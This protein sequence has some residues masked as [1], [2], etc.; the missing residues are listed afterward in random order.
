MSAGSSDKLQWAEVTEPSE[1]HTDH[2][3]ASPKVH[4]VKSQKKNKF[5]VECKQCD[6]S[7][8]HITMENNGL[9]QTSKMG[10]R[11]MEEVSRKEN[12]FS[13]CL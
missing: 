6:G 11:K 8:T 3:P 4:S 7:S 2:K 9:K 13:R 12:V 1:N 10:F 5:S